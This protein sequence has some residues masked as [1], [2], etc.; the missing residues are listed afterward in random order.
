MVLTVSPLNIATLAT[1]LALAGCGVPDLGPKPVPRGPEAI[2]AQQSLPESPT[3]AWPRDAW[4]RD[5]G[6]PQLT[7][8]IE[9]GL[10]ASPDVATAAA[11]YRRAA[12]STQQAG[13]ATLP[14]LD[15]RGSASLEKQSYNNGFPPQFLPQGWNDTG[16]IAASFNFDLDL[17]G[18]NRAALAAATSEQRA[19]QIDVRQAELM[20]STG[21]ASAYVDLALLFAVRGVRQA[22][23]TIRENSRKLV[24]DRVGQGLDN[25]GS[26]AQASAQ[27]ATA[28]AALTE[29]DQAIAMRRH[30]LAMLVGAGPDRGLAITPPPLSGVPERG[31]PPSVTTDL[32]GRRPDVV[33]ARERVE[34]T[35]S[36]I[37]V[38]RADFFPAINLSALVGFQSL[39]L[40][41]LL[42]SGSTFGQVGPAVTLPIF[43]GGALSGAYRGARAT[44]DEAVAAY[45]RSVLTAY[46]EAADAVT[47]QQAV[48]RRMVDARAA[49]ASSNQA[50]DIARRRYQGGLSNYLD[51]LIVED[52]V[53]QAQTAVAQ[54]E[55]AARSA[56]VALVRALGGGFTTKEMPHA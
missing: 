54:L 53:V 13:A 24:S 11:R 35:A 21:I 45:D 18:K 20:L 22:E 49:L 43:R 8:L 19:A 5:Y 2:A 42:S 29:A 52:R 32:I 23:L 56:D 16:Q 50:Y 31:L 41:N 48:A 4:W 30:Q 12:G 26:L 55:A 7:A 25:Q 33:A 37:K 38:A 40:S 46:Q 39:G 17:W 44:Y 10:K 34:A 47:A 1:A 36:R 51:V 27:T 6:D 14:S 3:A 9:E 28:R 15:L